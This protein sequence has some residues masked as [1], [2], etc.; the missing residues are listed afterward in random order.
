MSPLE[1]RSQ[2][3]K[4]RPSLLLIP[5]DGGNLKIK[6]AGEAPAILSNFFKDLKKIKIKVD[7]FNFEES[8][9]NISDAAYKEFKKKNLV[10]G[11]GGDHSVTYGLVRGAKKAFENISLLYFDAHL[12]AEDDFLPPS[13]EDVIQ[14]IVN[15]K[16][17]KPSNILIVG[18]RKY[19][20][21]EIEFINKNNIKVAFASEKKSEISEKI[22]KFVE[23]SKNLYVSVDIDFFDESIAKSTGYPEK[24]G[25]L[26]EDFVKFTTFP[27]FKRIIGYDLVE[28]IPSIDNDNIT[29]TLAS[30]VIKHLLTKSNENIETYI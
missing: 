17:I 5:F 24:N 26:L 27:E 19:W 23:K 21:K 30:N 6:G 8:Q 9:N 20:K 22:R 28:L 16:L 10:I 13:H 14:A 2:K 12:D 11:I 29:T 3:E 25:F 4:R 18:A 15:E 7:N 1:K